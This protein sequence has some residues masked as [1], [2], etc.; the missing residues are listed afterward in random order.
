MNKEITVFVTMSFETDIIKKEAARRIFSLPKQDVIL[1]D[2]N[3]HWNQNLEISYKAENLKG[4]KAF[5]DIL[6]YVVKGYKVT[7]HFSMKQEV[8]KFESKIN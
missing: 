7:Y 5:K 3:H 6:L 4:A 2:I 8:A 1:F